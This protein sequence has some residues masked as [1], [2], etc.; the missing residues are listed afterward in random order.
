MRSF[1]RSPGFGDETDMVRDSVK[2]L[3]ADFPGEYWR[4]LD[5]TS[6]YP[7]QFVQALS[8]A[9]FL[10]MLIPTQY[11]GSGSTLAETAVVLEEVH[12]NG[13][14]GAAAHAQMYEIVLSGFLAPSSCF[15]LC[16]VGS[17]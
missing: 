8:D 16:F 13:C 10:S 2:A 6:T 9:G 15:F 4:T 7:Y 5:S 3:C 17:C 1:T 14:N 11:G 12:G